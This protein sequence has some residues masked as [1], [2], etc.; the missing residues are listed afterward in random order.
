LRVFDVTARY[1][2]QVNW[3]PQTH[4]HVYDSQT[5]G[6][7]CM[8]TQPRPSQLDHTH[9]SR[10]MATSTIM[11]H[12]S[13]H[14]HHH[15]HTPPPPPT[16]SLRPLLAGC[17]AAAS[18]RAPL[19]S[20]SSLGTRTC[21]RC[22]TYARTTARRRCVRVC[23]RVCVGVCVGVG[24]CVFRC[25]LF[26]CGWHASSHAHTH[27]RPAHPRPARGTCST[28]CGSPTSSCGG[29]R[30]TASGASCARTSA[31]VRG[32]GCGG[33]GGWVGGWVGVE[34]CVPYGCPDL[35]LSC[36]AFGYECGCW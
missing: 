28:G 25:P 12:P 34:W 9:V 17:R 16:H 11:W 26:P 14:F 22:W 4:T 15:T 23:V 10:Q 36:I 29:S 18:A 20:T 27:T 35:W 21:S 33:V 32:W 24:V 31:Q 30:R 6:H 5:G 3:H 1:V 7:R 8:A 19:P 2:D 13:V